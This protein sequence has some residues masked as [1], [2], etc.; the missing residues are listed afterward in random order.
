MAKIILTL[1]GNALGNNAKEQK[2]IVKKAALVVAKLTIEN[3]KILI[4][5]GNGPQVGMINNAFLNAKVDMPF[6]ECG[7]M[8]QGYIGYHL[9]NAITN[10]F[11]KQK[12][13]KVVTTLV[14]QTIVD[15]KDKA[16]LDASKPIGSFM[17]EAEAKKIAKANG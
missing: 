11:R 14:T 16:F 12:I 15:K 4:C 2:E 13:D 10:E 3:H 9:Q 6:A 8:S 7:S 5:H 1:G 17:T